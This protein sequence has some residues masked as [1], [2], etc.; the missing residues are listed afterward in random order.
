[1]RVELTRGA[2]EDLDHLVRTLSLPSDTRERVRRSLRVLERFPLAG[3]VLEGR[4]RGVRFVLGPWRWLVL[5]YVV[6]ED[7]GRAVVVSVQDARAGA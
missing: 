2:V 5:A 6:L 3:P 1:M 7:E 4:G